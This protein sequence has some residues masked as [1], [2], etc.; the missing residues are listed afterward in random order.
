MTSKDIIKRL[1]KEGWKLFHTKGSHHQFK[2]TITGVKVTIPHP[3]KEKA[4]PAN[5]IQ[6]EH[7]NKTSQ[8]K[9][10]KTGWMNQA[11]WGN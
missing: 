8:T 5:E 11:D 10:S 2:H 9:P 6:E 3:K 7:D 4:L 1:K